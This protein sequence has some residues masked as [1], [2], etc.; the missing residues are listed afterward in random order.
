MT[1][2]LQ[3]TVDSNPIP[4]KDCEEAKSFIRYDQVNNMVGPMQVEMKEFK[5]GQK[6]QVQTDDHIN[7]RPRYTLHVI[8]SDDQDLD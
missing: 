1:L 3:E 5:R 7:G 8:D 6:Y 2:K 4:L